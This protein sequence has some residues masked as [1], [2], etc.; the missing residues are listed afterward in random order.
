M[1]TQQKVPIFNGWK[2]QTKMNHSVVLHKTTETYLPP[3]NAKVTE[4]STINRYM[5]YLQELAKDMNMPYVNITLDVGAAMNACILIWNQPEL[6]SNIVI[7]L[8]SFHFLK[9]NFQV[10][11]VKTV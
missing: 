4:F 5:K 11:V 8:G 2:L 10:S 1:K 3:I 6:F 7:H 9:E